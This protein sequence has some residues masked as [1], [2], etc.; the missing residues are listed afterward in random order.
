MIYFNSAAEFYPKPL[1]IQNIVN[2]LPYFENGRNCNCN[3]DSDWCIQFRETLKNF[4]NVPDDYQVTIT[5]SAT[6]SANLILRSLTKDDIVTYDGW[7][8][9]CIVRTCNELTFRS[10]PFDKR[11]TNPTV[12]CF[13]HESNVNGEFCNIDHYLDSYIPDDCKIVI[14]ISQSIGNI[15]INVSHWV[16]EH[17]NIYL[18]GTFHK[19]MGSICGC[20]FI[21]HPKENFLKPLI[22]GGT[23]THSLLLRQP[24]EYPFYLESGTKNTMAIACAVKSMKIKSG[25][26]EE[27][28]K[29][30]NEL[31]N[32]FDEN[33][34]KK[35][36][37]L[38]KNNL[39][40]YKHNKTYCINLIPKNSGMGESIAIRLEK[41]YQIITRFGNH[42]S[43]LY[44]PYNGYENQG[45][46]RLSFNEYNTI[47]EIDCFFE[48]LNKIMIDLL[49][50]NFI[51]N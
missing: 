11:K 36:T 46:L 5:N 42:C 20:G 23:G 29:V 28:F 27:H 30:K 44:T 50:E 22:T 24:K 15:K 1:A 34:D 18:F 49:N 33:W 6:E 21:V 45:I 38:V 3:K 13:T 26:M 25:L 2:G 10:F 43:P 48:S 37:N 32:Y 17:S 40:L 8:H 12:C 9:N 14:D 35:T 39:L 4:L 7:S 51:T 41:D 47:N 19:A 31:V 16:N